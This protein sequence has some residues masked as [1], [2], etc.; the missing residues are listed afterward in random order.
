MTGTDDF[1]PPHTPQASHFLIAPDRSG[2]CDQN[3]YFFIR[4]GANLGGGR[5][6]QSFAPRGLEGGGWG[7]VGGS[8]RSEVRAK[9]GLSE[10]R[11]GPILMAWG[12]LFT[13]KQ[14]IHA[15]IALQNDT[16]NLKILLKNIEQCRQI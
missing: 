5:P 12:R 6:L 1:T 7:G 3:A 9:R 4:I 13:S 11:S 16:P 10:A 8:E 2:Q 15:H 14:N